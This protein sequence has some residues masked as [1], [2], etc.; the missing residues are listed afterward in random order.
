[1]RRAR[2]GW[3]RVRLHQIANVLQV[4]ISYF[5]E[6]APGRAKSKGKAPSPDYVTDFTASD[7]GLALAKAFTKI[8]DPT[9]RRSITIMVNAIAG[10][11][12]Q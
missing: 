1:M 3:D 6:D 11:E 12:R 4:P 8:K 7:E 2:T 9:V 5:F 10:P